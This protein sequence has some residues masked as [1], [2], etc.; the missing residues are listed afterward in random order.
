MFVKRQLVKKPYYPPMS[1]TP[2]FFEKLSVH[3]FEKIWKIKLGSSCFAMFGSLP[4][5]K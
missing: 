1:Q 4:P 3:G 5:A 2:D